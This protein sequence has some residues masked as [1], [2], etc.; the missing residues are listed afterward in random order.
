MNG[1]TIQWKIYSTAISANSVVQI[2]LPLAVTVNNIMNIQVTGSYENSANGKVLFQVREIGTTYISV[3]N[4]G[5]SGSTKC[6]L[7]VVSY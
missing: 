5:D 4:S 6:L 2:P 1:L 7:Y 3:R